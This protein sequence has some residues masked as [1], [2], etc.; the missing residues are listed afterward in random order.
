MKSLAEVIGQNENAKYVAILGQQIA[1]CANNCTVCALYPDMT[2]L[3]VIL[4]SSCP[5]AK[6]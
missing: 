3:F 1:K 5:A 6:Q 2:R 4:R